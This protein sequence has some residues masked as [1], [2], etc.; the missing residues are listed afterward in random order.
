MQK[1]SPENNFST[2]TW[3]FLHYLAENVKLVEVFFLKGFDTSRKVVI[4]HKSAEVP[5][6]P[7]ML[8]LR[9]NTTN[10]SLCLTFFSTISN[11]VTCLHLYVRKA[12]RVKKVS[13]DGSKW[14]LSIWYSTW[15]FSAVSDLSNTDFAAVET[16]QQYSCNYLTYFLLTAKSEV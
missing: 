3:R 2:V 13:L 7:N 16:S 14:L 9:L 4:I 8:K 12:V 11:L 6:N 5:N 1:W 10:V 15:T